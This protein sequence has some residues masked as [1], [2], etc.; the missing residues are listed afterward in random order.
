MRLKVRQHLLLVFEVREVVFCAHGG[1]YYMAMCGIFSDIE[2]R[3]NM[4]NQKYIIGGLLVLAVLAG[5]WFMFSP[6]ATNEASEDAS[7]KAPVDDAVDVTIGFY[8]SW[9]ASVQDPETDPYAAG[10]GTDDLLSDTVR[11]YIV[12]AQRNGAVLE[13]DPVLCLAFVPEKVRAKSI[14]SSDTSAEVQVLGRGE[15]EKTPEYA[16]VGL[17]A[18]DGNWQISNITCVSGESA[19]E[20]EFAFDQEGFLLKGAPPLL[21]PEFW[22]VV[23]EENGQ[24]GH[25][26]PLSFSAASVC[27]GLDGAEATC[28]PSQFVNPS[29]VHVQGGMTEAGAVVQR[30]QMLGA[31]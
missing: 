10:L 15:G 23:F 14:F 22:Y 7:S 19:P 30:I 28:D 18:V 13:R 29:K 9:L 12:D 27:I 16:L 1:L 20:R 31:E 5:A 25:V 26:A 4:N 8:K 21:D 17:T 2:I 24:D 6:S 3:N 11:T